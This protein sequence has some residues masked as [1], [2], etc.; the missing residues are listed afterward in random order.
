M[1]ASLRFNALVMAASLLTLGACDGRSSSLPTGPQAVVTTPSVPQGQITVVSLQ[2]DNAATLKAVRCEPAEPI[3]CNRD[4]QLK[5]NVQLNQDVAAVALSTDFYNGSQQCAS[6]GTQP[7]SIRANAV[8]AFTVD[9]ITFTDINDG[10]LCPLPQST[11]RMVV[12]LRMIAPGCPGCLL[13]T[14]EFT[15]LYTFV[16]E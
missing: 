7:Q 8:A 14:R 10:F 12:E 1:S 5:F 9:L 16:L 3:Y 4:A 6:G 2:P 11:T 13:L 15:L